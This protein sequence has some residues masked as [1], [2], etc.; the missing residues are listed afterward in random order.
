MNIIFDMDG[1]ILDS[2]KVYLDGYLYAAGI[3]DLPEDLVR[4]AVI[5][6]VGCTEEVEK[7]VMDET[8]GKLESYRFDDAFRLSREYFDEIIRTGR[9]EL[10]PGAKELL[11][12]LRD[13]GIRTGLASS[14]PS[15]A[16]RIELGAHNLLDYFDVIISG[17]MVTK[18]KP[19]PEIFLLCA[20]HLGISPEEYGETYIIE[21]SYNGIRAAHA[22]GMQPVMVP[23]TLAPTNEMQDLAC[24][25]LPSLDA[26]KEWIQKTLTV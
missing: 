19:D 13:S 24:Q 9:I 12:W 25:I 10:K 15:E 17:D 3:L 7:R 23:D 14:S 2:E 26:G 6:C 20:K 4:E 22:S 11:T 21:D 8:F 1:V 16:I 18:S 5:R